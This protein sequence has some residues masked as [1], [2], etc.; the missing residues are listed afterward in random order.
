MAN[1]MWRAAATASLALG[2][3]AAAA[4]TARAEGLTYS[5]EDPASL[6]ATAGVAF[7]TDGDAL[8]V[9]GELAAV[10][11]AENVTAW[12]L[13]PTQ[14]DLTVDHLTYTEYLFPLC[15]S[16]GTFVFSVDAPH[17]YELS[18]Q[19]SYGP[20]DETQTVLGEGWMLVNLYDAT[21]DT[22]LF[23]NSQTSAPSSGKTFV[24]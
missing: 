7:G 18:G 19:Y 20:A 24:L 23:S 5:G 22:Y 4:G 13:T 11:R 17:T 1:S 12:T 3:L 14:L 6:S 10:D 9:D 16:Q 8:T 21:T 15:E 2:L